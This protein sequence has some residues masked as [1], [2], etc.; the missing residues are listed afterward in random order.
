[1]NISG[2]TVLI[3]GGATGIGYALAEAF[4]DAGN[5]VAIC[6]RR[7]EKLLEARKNHPDLHVTVCDVSDRE[8]RKSLLEWVTGEFAGL[9]ILINN[10]GIQRSIDLTHGAEDLPL[11]EIKINLEAPVYLSALFIPHL[12]SKKEAALINVSSGLAFV[13]RAKSPVYCATKAALHSFTLSLRHQL[14]GTGIKVFEA[15]PPKVDTDLNKNGRGIMRFPHRGIMP[16]EFAEAVMKGLQNDEPEI[17]HKASDNIRTGSKTDLER[18][19]YHM[20]RQQ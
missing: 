13:P 9:N 1:M 18:I 19:F 10:A 8:G 7:E 12:A 16:G 4:L 6:G 2:N 3:T 17:W 20:N 15:I 5:E 14:S 11:D